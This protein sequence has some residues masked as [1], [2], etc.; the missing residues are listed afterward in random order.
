MHERMYAVVD[1]ETT[2]L[3]DRDRVVEIAVVMLD[4]HLRVERSWETVINPERDVPTTFIHGLSADQCARGPRFADIAADCAALLD[5]R[6]LVAHNASFEW[7]FLCSEFDRAGVTVCDGSDWVCTLQG[8][9]QLLP[10]SPGR[11][12][13]CL[14]A[15]GIHNAFP[16]SAGGDAHATAELF[17]ELRRRD[18]EFGVQASCVRLEGAHRL[19][20]A[21]H[22]MSRVD[23]RRLEQPPSELR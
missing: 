4:T 10:G 12:S 22:V 3:G 9:R 21:A 14:S 6:V 23:L 5:G 15:T 16:H 20:R 11:L 13:R 1:V 19:E 7:R 17:A 2:G 18:P 8:A